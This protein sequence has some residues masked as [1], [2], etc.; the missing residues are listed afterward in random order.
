MSA[1]TLARTPI[2]QLLQTNAFIDRH[3]GPSSAENEAMLN[4]LQVAS[5]DE[6]LDQTVPGSI[7]LHQPLD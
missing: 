4:H 2:A 7:R 3:I 1:P 5:I 6:L